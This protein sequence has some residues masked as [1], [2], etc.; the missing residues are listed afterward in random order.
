MNRIP[1][2]LKWLVVTVVSLALLTTFFFIR[3]QQQPDVVTNPVEAGELKT[4]LIQ[5]AAD[6]K[7]TGGLALLVK[8]E[9]VG[10]RVFNISPRVVSLFGNN[11]LMTAAQAGTQVAP[12]VVAQALASATG[13]RIDGTLTMQ[14]LAIAG[15]VDGVGGVQ[16]DAKSGL[17]VSGPQ[18]EAK[19]VAPGIQTLDGQHAAGYAMIRQVI[20][21]EDD[22]I[23]RMNEI[24]RALFSKLP[25]DLAKAEETIVALG[26]L[27]R[28]N[29]STADISKFLVS[30]NQEN[31]W[32]SVKF[33]SVVT[34]PSELQ[35]SGGSD[36]LRVRQPDN[37]KKVAKI[38]PRS[39]MHFTDTNMRVEV[40]TSLPTDRAL[41]ASQIAELGFDFID[42]GYSRTPEVTT[43]RTSASVNKEDIEKLKAKLGLEEITE[44]WDFTL[45]GY[46][47][48]RLV[49]GADYVK[50]KTG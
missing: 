13:I 6:D 30:L 49:I 8:E 38:A 4:L 17:L 37:F 20:E 39:L 33:T 26:S 23:E 32:Q 1:E 19:Y 43:I 46:A 16:V 22:Q 2:F 14:R 42:G 48:V 21:T 3:G 9:K 47:D 34:D 7:Q 18:E 45:A 36:W 40:A 31:L 5:L 25:E 29:V 24:I 50:K 15:L 12:D 44:T 10:L 11:G 35:L 28:S 27:A 41:I